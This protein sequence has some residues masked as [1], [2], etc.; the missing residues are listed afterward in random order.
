MKAIVCTEFGSPDVLR[1]EEVPRPEPK[2]NEILVRVRASSVNFGDIMAR[3][4]RSVT[5]RGFNM[6]YLFWLVAKMSMGWRKPRIRVLGN[7]LAGEVEAVGRDVKRFKPGD[8]V[9]GRTGQ[10]FGA[11]AEFIC[12]PE[13]APVAHKPANLSYE[14]AAVIPTGPCMAVFLLRRAKLRPGAEDPDQRGQRRDR[15][16]RDADRQASRGRR[17]RGVRRRPAG[18]RPGPAARTGPSITPSRTSPKTARL[19]T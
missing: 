6:P 5:P 10:R 9:F 17:D 15:R 16:G 12:L 2:R 3:S 1:L 8:R 19:T 7:E 4:F 14:E 11:Y 18:L 13:N